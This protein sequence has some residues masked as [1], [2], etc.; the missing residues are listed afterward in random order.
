MLEVFHDKLTGR[1]LRS[2]FIGDSTSAILKIVFDGE[3]DIKVIRNFITYT[4]KVVTTKI[5][6]VS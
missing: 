5:T 1:L 3:T 6:E 4:K 2:I